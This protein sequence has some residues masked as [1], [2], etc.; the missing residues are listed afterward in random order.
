MTP[1]QYERLTELFH[2]ALELARDERAAFLDQ[3]SKGDGDVRR[4]LESLLASH[5]Q[6]TFAE[7]PPDDIAAGYLAQEGGSSA[8]LP[9][10]AHNTRLDHY[11][12]RSLLCKGGMGEVN[13]AVDMRL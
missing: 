9:L 13:L 7:T 10:F 2:A 6:G 5:E 11:A 3:V 4:E 12:I 8:S 1:Q